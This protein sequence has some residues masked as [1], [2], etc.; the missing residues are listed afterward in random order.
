MYLG[1]GCS[2]IQNV[3][4]EEHDSVELNE[5]MEDRKMRSLICMLCCQLGQLSHLYDSV[6]V[7]YKVGPIIHSC[8]QLGLLAPLVSGLVWTRPFLFIAS[9]RLSF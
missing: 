6:Y 4:V 5:C 9:H 7:L 2:A 8:A 3:I 1:A